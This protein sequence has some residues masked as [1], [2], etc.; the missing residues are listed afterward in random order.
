MS[1]CKLFVTVIACVAMLAGLAFSL[2]SDSP[3]SL[4]YS[5]AVGG[6][7]QTSQPSYPFEDRNMFFGLSL[8]DPTRHAGIVEDLGISW[9]S[10]QPHVLWM[11]IERD[12]G[13]YDWSRLDEEVRALQSFDTDVLVTRLVTALDED[14]APIAWPAE[15]TPSTALPVSSAPIFVE[16]R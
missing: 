2:S 16:L 7:R 4:P 13:V 1:T 9:L 11:A 15:V 5:I 6:E 10:L 14:G 12:P 8:I 3:T